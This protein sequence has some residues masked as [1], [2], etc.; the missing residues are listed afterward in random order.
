MLNATIGWPSI[1][2]FPFSTGI[3]R[4]TTAAWYVHSATLKTIRTVN[5]KSYNSM[6]L[7]F[8]T[9]TLKN[10]MHGKMINAIVGWPSIFEHRLHK[11]SPHKFRLIINKCYNRMYIH[12]RWA[13]DFKKLHYNVTQLSHYTCILPSKVYIQLTVT[14]FQCQLTRVLESIILLHNIM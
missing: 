14:V 2:A 1:Y 9:S 4:Y 3:L 5:D 13:R 7:Q 6:T 11:Q 10:N 12:F 8:L